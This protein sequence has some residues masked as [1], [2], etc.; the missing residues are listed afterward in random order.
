[1]TVEHFTLPCFLNVLVNQFLDGGHIHV[2]ITAAN[3]YKIVEGIL[4]GKFLQLQ[5]VARQLYSSLKKFRR[6][7]S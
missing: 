5:K 3:M 7:A 1:M 4:C 2:S 6:M